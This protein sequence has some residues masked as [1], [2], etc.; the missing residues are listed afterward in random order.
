[1]GTELKIVP[2]KH[3]GFV[4]LTSSGDGYYNQPLFAGAIG[5]AL[6]FMRQKLTE[7]PPRVRRNS[8]Q[9][10]HSVVR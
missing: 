1:V 4:V 8:S 3:G 10:N 7:P 9:I 6:E 5:E 2:A